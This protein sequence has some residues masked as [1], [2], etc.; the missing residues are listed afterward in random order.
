MAVIG[1]GAFA[2]N[3][4]RIDA[5]WY[6]QHRRFADLPVSRVAYV[7]HGSG[8]AALFVHG[9]PLNGYQWRGALE[10][11]GR[12]IGGND[13]LIA[14]HARATGAI[15]VTANTDEFKRVRGL[16]VENWSV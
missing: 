11:Q 1:P 2:K 13:M 8:P 6:R 16:K 12:P 14:A 10:R 4:E 5:A 9:Y 15:V 3:A 7:E